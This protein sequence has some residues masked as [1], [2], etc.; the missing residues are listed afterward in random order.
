MTDGDGNKVIAMGGICEFGASQ[1]EPITEDGAVYA[2]QLPQAGPSFGTRFGRSL[3]NALRDGALGQHLLSLTMQ[4]EDAPQR[5]NFVDLDTRYRDVFG[6]PVARVTYNNHSYELMARKFYLPVL[7]QVLV[8]AGVPP[9]KMFVTPINLALVGPP[10]SHH[11]MGTLRMGNDPAT[12]VVNAAG[13]F[14]DIDNFYACDGSVFVTSSGYNP[15]LTII[16]LALKIAHALAGT[17]PST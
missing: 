5:T 7:K 14:H 16:A 10:N 8:N 9:E 17:S 3:K 6:R 1:G 12:S 13:R 11:I 15:T 4:A 2:L